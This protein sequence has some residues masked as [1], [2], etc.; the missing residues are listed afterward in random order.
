MVKIIGACGA[1]ASALCAWSLAP[2]ALSPAPSDL[3][4]AAVKSDQI[5]ASERAA[6]CSEYG[7]PY[8]DSAC[9]RDARR[10]V[11]EERKVRFVLIDRLPPRQQSAD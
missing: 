7:W 11:G 8:Y 6:A 5:D 1:A 9:L 4:I 3:P 2:G 10:P